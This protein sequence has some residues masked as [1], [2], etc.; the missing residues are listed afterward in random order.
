MLTVIVWFVVVL[1]GMVAGRVS[2]TMEPEPESEATLPGAGSVR[3]ALLP[4]ASRI[5]APLSDRASA[6]V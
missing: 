4:A 6:P 5:V 3:L 2:I 1:V